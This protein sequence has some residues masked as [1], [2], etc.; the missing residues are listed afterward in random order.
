M[1]RH[2]WSLVAPGASSIDKKRPTDS[3]SD[4]DRNEGY[5]RVCVEPFRSS[6]WLDSP[7]DFANPYFQPTETAS[8]LIIDGLKTYSPTPFTAEESVHGLAHL[9]SNHGQVP[10]AAM[11]NLPFISPDTGNTVVSIANLPFSYPD[12]GP[13]VQALDAGLNNPALTDM[14]QHDDNEYLSFPLNMYNHQIQPENDLGFGWGTDFCDLNTNLWANSISSS[15]RHAN[16]SPK[17]RLQCLRPVQDQS[18]DVTYISA[19]VENS[20]VETDTKATFS[21]EWP[22]VM[23]EVQVEKLESVLSPEMEDRYH[24]QT[25]SGLGTTTLDGGMSG[26]QPLKLHRVQVL[27]LILL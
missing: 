20:M 6:M 5:K 11:A 7:S 17:E 18:I 26:N 25:A 23:D 15:S 19:N 10:G 2:S 13:G 21:A 8:E 12:T 4:R 14:S 9:L 3:L 16:S 1:E 24:P 22:Y 27:P